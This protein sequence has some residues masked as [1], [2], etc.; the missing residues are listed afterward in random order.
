MLIHVDA[1]TVRALEERQAKNTGDYEI[2]IEGELRVDKVA[3]YISH[4]GKCER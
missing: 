1:E 2:E 4:E 3:N